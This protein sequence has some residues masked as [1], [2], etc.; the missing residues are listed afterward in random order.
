[1]HIFIILI[2]LRCISFTCK[3]SKTFLEHIYSHRLI[4]CNEHIDSQI[5]LMTIDQQWISNIS[6]DNASFININIINIINN[7]NT[8]SLRRIGWLHYPN[9]LLW[10]MLL[11]LLIMSIEISELI[12][13]DI[14]IRYEVEVLLSKLF[15]HSYHIVTKSV[16]LC[17]FIT[18]RKVINFLVFI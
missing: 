17:D 13:K 16:F 4:T 7:I 5:E 15:L 1:M 14:S 10:I 6:T 11:Q 9:I 18:L 8:F 2:N 3:S 12:W